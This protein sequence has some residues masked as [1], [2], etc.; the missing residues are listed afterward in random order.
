MSLNVKKTIQYV[1][2]LSIG[3]ALL[4]LTFR[5]TNPADLWTNIRSVDGFG[6][7]LA[8]GIGFIA[9]IIRGIRWVQL[10]ASLGYKVSPVNAISAVAFSYLVNL[11]TPRVGE[12]AR[13]TALNRTDEVPFDKLFG[14]VVLERVVDT[15]MFGLVVLVTLFTQA[16]QL[17]IFL[18]QSGADIPEL[19]FGLI[20]GL[21]AGMLLLLAVVWSTRKI[22]SQWS[23]VQKISGF[24]WGIVEGLKSVQKV[25]NKPLFW[26][27]SLA[28]WGCY[29]GTIVVGFQIVDGLAD[30]GVG[31][32]FYISVAAALGFVVPVP[33]GIGAYHYLVSKALTVLGYSP[34]LGIA[35]ATIIHSGQSLMFITTG[36]IGMGILYFARK[37]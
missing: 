28:I 9:I 18:E 35:F 31:A 21:I 33:G 36:A 17:G 27:Y 19:S 10:L 15:L 14:T 34:D 2:F 1:L 22:W 3:I 11:V 4:Y 23:F 29:V 12:V 8:L 6:L 7:L 32:A 5:N 30:L 13:C 26:L 25:E 16:Q 20:A 24:L 37:K